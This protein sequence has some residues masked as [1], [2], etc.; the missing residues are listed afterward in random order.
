MILAATVQQVC[1]YCMH[2]C[3]VGFQLV[4]IQSFFIQALHAVTCSSKHFCTRKFKKI[5]NIKIES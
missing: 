1:F 2:V 3:M 5:T 4:L